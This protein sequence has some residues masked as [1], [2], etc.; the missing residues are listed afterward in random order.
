MV[1]RSS[2]TRPMAFA[3]AVLASA[4]IVILPPG[5][6]ASAAHGDCRVTAQ[7]PFIYADLVS[8]FTAIECGTVKQ[9][10]YIE[11]TLEMDGI[12]RRVLQPDLPED[13]HV[14]A[15]A[16]Q[17]RHLHARRPGG[18]ALVRHGDRVD[19]QPRVPPLPGPGRVV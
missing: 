7:G 5:E 2:R 17:R 15:G 4:L 6:E 14:L 11:A 13:Q 1:R 12:R 19:Q 9:G 3:V 16:G 10:I 18:P 8:P